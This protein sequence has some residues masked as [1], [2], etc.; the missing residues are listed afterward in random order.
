ME[1]ERCVQKGSL[2]SNIQLTLE[3]WRR[4]AE[5][6]KSRGNSKSEIKNM[7]CTFVDVQQAV[8]SLTTLK[9][10]LPLWANLL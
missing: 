10:G 4:V 8:G 7:G 6:Q 5:Q 2:R 3:W 9:G 1:Q